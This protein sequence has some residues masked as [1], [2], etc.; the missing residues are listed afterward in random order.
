MPMLCTMG[1]FTMTIIKGSEAGGG[2]IEDTFR[3]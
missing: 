2:L 1:N 3:I